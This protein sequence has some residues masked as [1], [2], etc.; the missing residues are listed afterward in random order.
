MGRNL[1]IIGLGF[2][3]VLA[4]AMGIN[5][6]YTTFWRQLTSLPKRSGQLVTSTGLTQQQQQL[7]AN[8]QALQAHPLTGNA[9][10]GH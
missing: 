1:W 3:A 6:S 7:A 8:I 4:I 5:G 10:G 9:T 2:L